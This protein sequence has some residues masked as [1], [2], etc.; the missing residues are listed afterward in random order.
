[1]VKYDR[2]QLH[3]GLHTC[4]PGD[5]SRIKMALTKCYGNGNAPKR[6]M[7]LVIMRMYHTVHIIRAEIDK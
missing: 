3:F 7:P 6:G 2:R 4:P 5:D 1:M